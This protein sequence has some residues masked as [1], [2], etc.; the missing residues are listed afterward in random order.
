LIIL[1]L[2][3]HGIHDETFLGMQREVL[4]NLDA[5]LVNAE[6]AQ[7]MLSQIGGPASAQK[8]LLL[9]MMLSG[10]SPA[11]DPFL[12]SCFH[13]IRSHHIDGLRKKAR[14]FIEKGALLMVGID[15]IAGR[16]CLP[17]SSEVAIG[18]PCIHQV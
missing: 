10:I 5:F 13:A 15:E 18:R 11:K 16:M 12:Y 14:I 1:L 9:D 7:Q 4:N 17:P 2:R 3:F 6:A 8:S